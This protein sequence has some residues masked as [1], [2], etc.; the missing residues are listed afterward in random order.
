MKNKKNDKVVKKEKSNRRIKTV[1]TIITI[2]IIIL[3]LL[4]ACGKGKGEV[5]FSG[6]ET[7]I[8][9]FGEVIDP[10]SIKITENGKEIRI[11][12]NIDI[13]E[14]DYTKLGK[15]PITVS[16]T[17]KKGRTYEEKRYVEIKDTTPPII[18]LKGSNPLTIPLKSKYN[19]PGYEVFDNYDK[20]ED[21][22]VEVIGEVDITKVGEYIITYTATDTSG[23]KSVVTRK[24]IVAE[25]KT[26]KKPPV[27][28]PPTPPVEPPVQPPTNT[29]TGVTTLQLKGT[30][31]MYLEYLTVYT[32]PGYTATDT[33]D[34]DITWKVRTEGGVNT[35]VLGTYLITYE[36]ANSKGAITFVTR[37]VIVKD[38]VSPVLEINGPATIYIEQ[39]AEYIDLGATAVDNHDGV[40]PVIVYN[41]VDTEYLGTYYVIYTA[42]DSSGNESQKVRTVIVVDPTIPEI[43]V[44]EPTFYITGANPL[45]GEP[46]DYFMR[47][48]SAYD[49]KDGDLT[50]K[51]YFIIDL[52]DDPGSEPFECHIEDKAACGEWFGSEAI[53]E[54]AYHIE[55]FVVDSDGHDAI[56]KT[57]TVNVIY[58]PR[59]EST[60]STTLPTKDNVIAYIETNREIDTPDGWTKI[61][62]THFSKEYDD[63]YVGEVLICYTVDTVSICSYVNIEILNIDKTLLSASVEYSTTAQTNRDVIATIVTNKLVSTPDGW[64]KID[65]THYAKTYTDNTASPESVTLTDI[66]GNTDT[67]TVSVSNIDRIPPV[68]TIIGDAVMEFELGGTYIDEG[69]TALDD[70]DGPVAVVTTSNLNLSIPGTYYIIYKAVDSAGNI[71]VETREITIIGATYFAILNPDVYL[72]NGTIG[73][74]MVLRTFEDVTTQVEGYTHNFNSSTTGNKVLEIRKDGVLLTTVAYV[75]VDNFGTQSFLRLFGPEGGKVKIEFYSHAANFHVE[76]YYSPV[77]LVNPMVDINGLTPHHID[78]PNGIPGYQQNKNKWTEIN[79]S[80]WA[81]GYYYFVA[82]ESSDKNDDYKL[83]YLP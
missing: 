68:I 46:F 73:Q 83:L 6:S 20:L 27:T 71:A 58:D 10:H 36:V 33:V 1:L 55:Y 37:K 34:G 22:I 42:T 16:Y 35:A 45:V 4:K 39:D 44:E 2:I 51:I 40:I 9:E 15:Y 12:P 64:T 63:N 26:T 66:V 23:N 77:P 29:T 5:T 32:E 28:P 70:V 56:P 3:L 11:L 41:P 18:L 69:A 24:V 79:V 81:S 52:V 53:I 62:E 72:K 65:D 82:I 31:T 17:D 19:E 80:G 54:G 25:E 61:D 13:S 21:I 7:I 50:D 75:V 47:G 43:T 59:G 78:L 57:K 30:S 48:V 74:L 60:Y 67:V 38:T 49:I 76:Y 8:L 14:V